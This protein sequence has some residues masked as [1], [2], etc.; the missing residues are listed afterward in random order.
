[1]ELPTSDGSTVQVPKKMDEAD[2]EEVE[3]EGETTPEETKA[4]TDPAQLQTRSEEPILTS[5]PRQS[6]KPLQVLVEPA[7]IAQSVHESKSPP[8]SFKPHKSSS[9]STDDSAVL[10]SAPVFPEPP[11]DDPSTSEPLLSARSTT[12]E[13]SD[14]SSTP[15]DPAIMR[16]FPDVPDEEH[17][18]VEIHVSPHVTPA[19]SPLDRTSSAQKVAGPGSDSP[20]KPKKGDGPQTPGKLDVETAS[21]ENEAKLSKRRSVRRSPKSPLLD[22]ED[23]GDYVPGDEG[24]AVVTK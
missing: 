20:L 22:D 23:P 21:Y 24:W 16:S 17:P 14:R 18:R 4:N 6:D 10:P 2:E 19:K 15:L 5:P 13:P 1:M 11:H 9:P 8:S 3:A 7:P 12:T